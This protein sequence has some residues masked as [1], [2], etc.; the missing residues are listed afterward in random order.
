MIKML[1]KSNFESLS[2]IRFLQIFKARRK[3][4]ALKAN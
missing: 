3:Y 1:K 2:N 4:G